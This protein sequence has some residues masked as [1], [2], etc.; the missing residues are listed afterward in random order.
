FDLREQVTTVAHLVKTTGPANIDI[1]LEIPELL[2]RAMGDSG[3]IQQVILNLLLNSMEAMPDGGV[4]RIRLDTAQTGQQLALKISVSDEG[5]GIDPTHLSEV[6]DPFFST[7]SRAHGLGLT[8]VKRIIEMHNGD[9]SIVSEPGKGTTVTLHLP[10]SQ[11]QESGPRISAITPTAQQQEKLLIIDD[12]EG[13]RRLLG[14]I[15][16][17][18]GYEWQEAGSG[19]TGL[20]LLRQSPEVFN[21]VLLDL[22]MPGMDGWETLSEIR[23]FAPCLPVIII[24]GFDPS[25]QI[26]EHADPHLYFITKPF[27]QQEIAQIIARI[28]R[29]KQEASHANS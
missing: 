10:V 29:R 15:L 26:R 14:R 6:F 3:Q 5:H 9:I 13:I 1:E 27:R 11:E 19:A 4:I 17:N 2:P 28:I 16:S 8:T 21:I 20:T 25:G 23:T 12:E 18:E 24:S 7:K 22:K